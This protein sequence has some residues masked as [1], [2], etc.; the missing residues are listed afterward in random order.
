MITGFSIQQKVRLLETYS[1][2]PVTWIK[3]MEL[4]FPI[5]EIFQNDYRVSCSNKVIV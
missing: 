2:T 1:R 3:N 4:A 5:S